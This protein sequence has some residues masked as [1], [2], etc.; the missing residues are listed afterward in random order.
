[1]KK[2]KNLEDLIDALTI[3]PGVG[4]KSAQRMAYKILRSNKDKTLNLSRQLQN[5]LTDVD[6]E[7]LNEA[8]KLVVIHQQ[9]S[10]SLIQRRMKVGYSRAARLIDR[11]EQLGIVGPFTGSKAREVMV[12]ETYLEMIDD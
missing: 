4:R 3:L 6:D 8:I 12:D 11:M 2:S 7:L 10:I 9:G 5:V 1:M